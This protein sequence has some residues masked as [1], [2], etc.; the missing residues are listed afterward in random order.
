M[1]GHNSLGCSG[2]VSVCSAW[3][4]ARAPSEAAQTN[5]LGSQIHV[6][7]QLNL[8]SCLGALEGGQSQSCPLDNI[9]GA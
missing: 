9:S 5:T 2:L 7:Y 1:E 4:H 8:K 3:P 6:S